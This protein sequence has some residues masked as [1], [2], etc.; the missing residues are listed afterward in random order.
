M[1]ARRNS[2]SATESVQ[3]G[4]QPSEKISLYWSRYGILFFF[5]RFA[6][7]MTN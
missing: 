6:A 5:S 3:G 2:R 4:R 1:K 7:I